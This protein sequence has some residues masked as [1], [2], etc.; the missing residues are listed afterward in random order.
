MS[1]GYGGIQGSIVNL[2]AEWWGGSSEFPGN[3]TYGGAAL[4]AASNLYFGGNPPYQISDF[5]AVYPK[6]GVQPQGLVQVQPDATNPGA[7]YVAGDVLAVVASDAQGG[8]V[9]VA[10]VDINGVPLTYSI[11]AQGSGYQ[12]SQPINAI[13]TLAPAAGEGGL[14]YR[15]G[16]LVGV[17]QA[18]ASGALSQITAVDANGVV[19]AL[20][21]TAQAGCGYAVA[22]DLIATGGSGV[23]LLVD[24]TSIVPY[25]GTPTTGGTGG[26]AQVDILQITAPNLVGIPPLVLQMYV[27][28]AS[29]CL[30][31]ARWSTLW[32]LAMAEFVA[33]YATLYLRSE[34]STGTTP[35]QIAAS[36]LTRGIMVSKSAGGV[37]ATIQVPQGLEAWG[38]WSM[39]E[40][41][42]KLITWAEVVGAGPM[43]AV[44]GAGFAGPQF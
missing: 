8:A 35:G 43:Y 17:I 20:I 40:Y 1:A 12:V 25:A 34:G 13:G 27:N 18:G 29:S 32:P 10:T 38:A 7:G 6:F 14:G 37:S 11:S 31:A 4:T 23:G 30:Q 41:G 22:N 3:G 2:L 26:G 5:L 21:I 9:T 15:V 19:L 42:M 24:V 36:G 16:D 33:H 39:T 44:G 28:L